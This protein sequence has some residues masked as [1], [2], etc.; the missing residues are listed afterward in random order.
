MSLIELGGISQRMW[1]KHSVW[2]HMYE[3]IRKASNT[4]IIIK[5]IMWQPA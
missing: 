1:I 3:A 2:Y 5:K 4:T